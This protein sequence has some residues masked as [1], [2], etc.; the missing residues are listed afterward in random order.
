MKEDA[1]LTTYSISLPTRIALYENGLNV[2]LHTG[3][4]FRPS[5]LASKAVLIDC[6]KVDVEHKMYCNPEVRSLQD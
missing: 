1:I 6:E 5:T 3:E 4:G 2:Y